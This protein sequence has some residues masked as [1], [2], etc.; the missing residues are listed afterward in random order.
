M[1]QEEAQKW[2]DSRCW[3]NGCTLTADSTI[4]ALE[5]AGQ[6]ARNKE[7]WDTLFKFIAETDLSTLEAGSKIVLV[8]GRLW[9]NV[10]EYTPKSVRRYQDRIAP[11]H[12]RPAVYL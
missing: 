12:D 5:F 3:A 11:Q 8:E 1:T 10:L 7:L 6:Y 4:N 9:V 2:V